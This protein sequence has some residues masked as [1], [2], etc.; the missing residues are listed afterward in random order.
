MNQHEIVCDQY[1]GL[2]ES[3]GRHVLADQQPQRQ[4]QLVHKPTNG[5]D[6]PCRNEVTEPSD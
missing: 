6:Y 5:Q 3:I 4:R 1:F 2:M